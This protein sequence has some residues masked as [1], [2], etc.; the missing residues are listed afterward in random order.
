MQTDRDQSQ[1]SMQAIGLVARRTKGSVSHAAAS[2]RALDNATRFMV[3]VRFWSKLQAS[4]ERT[5]TGKP[6]SA[7][8]VNETPVSPSAAESRLRRCLPL[9]TVCGT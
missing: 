8:H 3:R 5:A 4:I 1:S 6:A 2:N 9:C 7:A